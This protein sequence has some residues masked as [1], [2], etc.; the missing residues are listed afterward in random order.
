MQ[1]SG[2]C[3]HHGRLREVT[4]GDRAD[5]G[6]T[7]SFNSWKGQDEFDTQMD[8]YVYSY[9]RIHRNSTHSYSKAIGWSYKLA[10]FIILLSGP[11]PTFDSFCHL[12]ILFVHIIDTGFRMGWSDKVS[13]WFCHLFILT[14]FKLRLYVFRLSANPHQHW[15]KRI[16][17]RNKDAFPQNVWTS[18]H[19]Q[20]KA[21]SLQTSEQ[22]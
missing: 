18:L 16:L 5:Q 7:A 12:S 4:T 13:I 19:G 14:D 11:L 9:V 8:K 3:T 22:Y 17:L 10:L 20:F 6:K 2:R 15:T 1:Y 21:F